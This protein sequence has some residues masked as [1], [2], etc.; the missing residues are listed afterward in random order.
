MLKNQLGEEGASA[1]VNVAEDK[2]LVTTLCGIKPEET[3][4]DLSGQ[5]LSV[6]DAVLLAFDLKQNDQLVELKCALHPSWHK[7]VSS[8]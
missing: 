1:I 6:G 4:R 2:P 8:R 3:K 5:N 7:N